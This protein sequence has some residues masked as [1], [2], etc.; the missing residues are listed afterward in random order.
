M[1]RKV[2]EVSESELRRKVEKKFKERADLYTHGVAFAGV[3]LAL[4]MLYFST[5]ASFPWPIFVTGGWG[6]GLVSHILQ[7]HYEHGVGAKK[8]EAEIEAEIE[9]QYRLRQMRRESES[10]EMHDA[11][12]HDEARVYDLDRVK[13]SRLRLNDDGELVDFAAL[14]D[15][16]T[17]RQRQA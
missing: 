10:A 17:K 7:Y 16:E 13:A 2:G 4:W 14:D 12:L 1:K 3:N 9:R 15:S 5:G 6:I 11:D 8:K